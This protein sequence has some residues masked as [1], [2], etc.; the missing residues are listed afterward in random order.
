MNRM[1]DT[2]FLYNSAVSK[3]LVD[4]LAEM[5]GWGT[6]LQKK[7]AVYVLQGISLLRAR[8][9]LQEKSK[10]VKTHLS[11]SSEAYNSSFHY[12][13]T[14][15]PASSCLSCDQHATYL[16]PARLLESST[17]QPTKCLPVS[18]LPIWDPAAS[19][20]H[21]LCHLVHSWQSIGYLHE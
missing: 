13:L 8:L 15:H 9:S 3:H 16:V 10:T 7:V 4:T 1:V 18:C 21:C 12:F 2:Y 6:G 20:F 17:S 5:L 14:L 11:P 19:V